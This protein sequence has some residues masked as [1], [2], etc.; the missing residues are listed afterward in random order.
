MLKNYFSL[1]M[2][3][4]VSRVVSF[5]W[6]IHMARYLGVADYG[7][8]S[9]VMAMIGIATSFLDLGVNFIIIREVVKKPEM[10]R[11]YMGAQIYLRIFMA[12]LALVFIWFNLEWS[13]FPRDIKI[14]VFIAG[15]H[16]IFHNIGMIGD[17]VF[18]AF[19]KQYLTAIMHTAHN[20]GWAILGFYALTTH[21]NLKALLV[22][23][24]V[25]SL[26]ICAIY[27]WLVLSIFG[28]PDFTIELPFLTHLVRLSLPIG[29]TAIFASVFQRIDKLMLSKFCGPVEVGLYSAASTLIYPI[30][31]LTWCAAIIVL[32]PYMAKLNEHPAEFKAVF[33]VV[34]SWIFAAI[35][36]CTAMLVA[37]PQQIIH[38]AFGSKYVESTH[39]LGILAL[40]MLSVPFHGFLARRLL[41]QNKQKA[42]GVANFFALITN[43]GLNFAMIP[44]WGIFGAA[45]AC[46]ITNSLIVFY[47]SICSG[48]SLADHLDWGKLTWVSV[49]CLVS[50]LI[51]KFSSF[52]NLFVVSLIFSTIYL[53][54]LFWTLKPKKE[55]EKIAGI[56]QFAKQNPAI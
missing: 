14:L 27:L 32:Y 49:F 33:R 31:D 38:F 2:S 35:A 40:Q 46:V 28:M 34:I 43:L 55:W 29:L 11:K 4:I 6:I 13:N 36:G 26:I 7:R 23:M 21:G 44:K 5:I 16:M 52:T 19:S 10:V 30:Q 53:A 56:L 12:V 42:Y 37:F 41:I 47:Y 18:A 24:A 20:V 22:A 8:Y 39:V 54:F 9:T 15:L 25:N 1:V 51:A 48:I 45:V 50:I 3:E 17:T